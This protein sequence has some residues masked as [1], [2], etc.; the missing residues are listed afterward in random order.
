M[1]RSFLR[2]R[3]LALAL[4]EIVVVGQLQRL[5]ERCR[6][7]RRCRRCGDRGLVGHGRGRDQVLLAQLHGVDAGDARGF[8]DRRA[9]ARSSPPAGRRRDRGRSAPCW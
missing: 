1:P 7:N 2:S 4:V 6:G 5:G 9:R 3:R 8:L